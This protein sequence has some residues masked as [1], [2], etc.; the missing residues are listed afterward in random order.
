M[1]L[2]IEKRQIGETMSL[3]TVQD[4]L[5]EICKEDNVDVNEYLASE[6]ATKTIEVRYSY[7]K[8]NAQRESLFNPKMTY[9][10]KDKIKSVWM[11]LESLRYTSYDLFD[12]KSYDKVDGNFEFFCYSKVSTPWDRFKRFI[13]TQYK[14]LKW[15]WNFTPE[16]I[17]HYNKNKPRINMFEDAME[18]LFFLEWDGKKDKTIKELKEN[19][20]RVEDNRIWHEPIPLDED[21]RII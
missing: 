6:N 10:W 9:D 11:Q 12:F 18:D 15:A 3:P 21:K 14:E 7:F 20:Y 17:K 8:R 2:P 5:K 13:K 4:Y 16:H 19:G 1:K